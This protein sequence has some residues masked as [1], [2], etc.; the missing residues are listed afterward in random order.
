VYQSVTNALNEHR[1]LTARHLLPKIQL[2]Y[3]VFNS[4]YDEVAKLIS[5]GNNENQ[6]QRYQHEL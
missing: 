1:L 3:K 5:G 2:W 4:F 6:S